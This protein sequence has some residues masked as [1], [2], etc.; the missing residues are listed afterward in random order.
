M[1]RQIFAKVKEHF[2]KRGRKPTPSAT[3]KKSKP[4]ALLTTSMMF[5]ASSPRQRV[6]KGKMRHFRSMHSDAEG[7]L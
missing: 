5:N 3:V 7:S 4:G 2:T 1:I 6:K